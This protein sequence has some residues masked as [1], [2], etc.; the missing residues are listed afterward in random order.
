MASQSA[1]PVGSCRTT[2]EGRRWLGG[3]LGDLIT[4]IT[5]HTHTHMHTHTHARTRYYIVHTQYSTRAHESVCFTHT[6]YANHTNV[7]LPE[8]FWVVSF[9]EEMESESHVWH[10]LQ[11]PVS[12]Y[13][14]T[15]QEG[16]TPLHSS[17][18]A[19]H[20]SFCFAPCTYL[21]MYTMLKATHFIT[22]YN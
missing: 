4:H 13:E 9:I 22:T 12:S 14:W 11:H 2:E 7:G 18:G 17:M 20:T 19:T 6:V 1:V 3:C 5:K 10:H 21:Y 15:C 16:E 8:R